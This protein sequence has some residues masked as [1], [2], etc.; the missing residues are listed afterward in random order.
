MDLHWNICKEVQ[1]KKMPFANGGCFDQVGEAMSKVYDDV[2]DVFNGKITSSPGA[3]I[4]IQKEV[5]NAYDVMMT[6]CFHWV[7]EKSQNCQE[8]FLDELKHAKVNGASNGFEKGLLGISIVIEWNK[9]KD[10]M[11]ELMNEK[12]WQNAPDDCKIKNETQASELAHEFEEI[13]RNVKVMKKT[14]LISGP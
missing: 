13:Y 7:D 12:F 11:G 8:Y 2:S 14:G 6:K 4:S 1:D 3:V 10:T 9:L 5:K